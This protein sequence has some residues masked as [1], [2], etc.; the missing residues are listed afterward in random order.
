MRLLRITL[1][2]SRSSEQSIRTATAL[3]V[4]KVTVSRLLTPPRSNSMQR[5]C[6]SPESFG[7]RNSCGFFRLRSHLSP[8]ST[9]LPLRVVRWTVL[10]VSMM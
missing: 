10:R 3:S 5:V 7:S 4:L 2:K 9:S 1:V 8:D 6:E